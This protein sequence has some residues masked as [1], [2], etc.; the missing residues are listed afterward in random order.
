MAVTPEL[1]APPR[2]E[3]VEARQPA[4]PPVIAPASPLV[5]PW[6]RLA[7]LVVVAVASELV[8]VV[9]WPLSYLLTQA[10]DFT[11]EYLVEYP[12]VWE[13]LVQMLARME[14][15][16]PGSTGS[17]AIL[18]DLLMRVFI[19]A[20]ILYM[21]AFFLTRAGLPRGWGV[22]AVLAPPLAFHITLFTMPGLFTTDLFSYA[23]YG[24]I[25]GVY[26]VS[27]YTHLPSEFPQFNIYNWI[28]PLWHDAPSIYGPAWVDLT[29]PI[30]RAVVGLSD[31]D[32]I[33]VYKLVSNVGHLLSV[34]CIAYAANKLRPGTAL[35]AVVLYAWNPL[36]L[37]E[38]GGNG[39]NDAV[40][41]AVM[42]LAVACYVSGSRWLGLVALTVSFLIKMTSVLLVPYYTMA[43]AR[44]Q[45]GWLRFFGIGFGAVATV[46]V[47]IGAFYYP[48]WEG[49]QTIGP[50]LLWSQ[51]P[52]FNNYVPDILAIQ[53]ATQR[54]IDSG[55]TLDPTVAL[56]QTR[57]L[58]KSVA[59]GLLIALAIWELWRARGA[60][61]MLGSGARVMMAFLLIVNT[62]VLPWY[63]AWPIALAV[64]LGWESLTTKVLIGLSISAPTVMYYH[65][66]WHP[67]MS[68][69][70][71][72][73]YVAP[74]A[75]APIAWIGSLLGWLWRRATHRVAA[76]GAT[77]KSTLSVVDAR[78]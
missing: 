61:G 74:L 71:Y 52:M 9:F 1:E 19:V 77:A 46:L 54:I 60:S 68:D 17:L 76:P 56:D 66:F 51:G 22:V 8:Y 33:L 75:I 39:H 35:Q 59:R 14:Q 29:R 26:G 65:H 55:G 70:T 45:R 23:D 38:F 72:L 62:W 42:M 31:V 49:P 7:T 5:W 28:H 25:A 47:V 15:F 34:G 24:Q 48:W 10:V 73:F 69:S 40:M 36:I 21:V 2:I 32:K 6:L 3:S 16:W 41:I 58:V 4:P 67:Y 43:W 50:I 53:L 64:V 57:D 27:P 13:R 63:F 18:I 11:Y 30:S 44:D 12:A 20:F 78:Q 37:F